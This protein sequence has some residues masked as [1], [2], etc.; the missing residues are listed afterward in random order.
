MAGHIYS[1]DSESTL[2]L[3]WGED[4]IMSAAYRWIDWFLSQVLY[5]SWLLR[6]QRLGLLSEAE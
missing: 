6:G 4:R 2:T 3:V 5:N 1:N